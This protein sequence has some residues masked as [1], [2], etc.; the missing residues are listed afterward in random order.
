MK[1]SYALCFNL[2]PTRPY[3][4]H[5]SILRTWFIPDSDWLLTSLRYKSSLDW[6]SNN[7]PPYGGG[8]GEYKHGKGTISL[9]LF[10]FPFFTCHHPIIK[11][12]FVFCSGS[13]RYEQIRSLLFGSQFKSAVSGSPFSRSPVTRS[14]F[15]RSPISRSPVTRSPYS[16]SP[17]SSGLE[18]SRQESSPTNPVSPTSPVFR[19][20]VSRSPV[21]WS[22]VSG[23]PWL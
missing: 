16:G 8:G 1:D 20:P 2:A 9:A 14:P 19:S 13:L 4:F 23:T 3:P 11:N 17:V 22:P 6:P 21:S 5:L 10:Q 7:C 18:S 15:S 12:I